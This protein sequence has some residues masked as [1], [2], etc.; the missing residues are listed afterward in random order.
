MCSACGSLTGPGGV[1]GLRIRE[2]TCCECGVA[3]DRDINA[4]RNILALGYER[5]SM[6]ITVL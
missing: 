5:P 2:W 3:H 4:G 6:R 1:N